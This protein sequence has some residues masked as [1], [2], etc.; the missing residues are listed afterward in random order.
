LNVDSNELGLSGVFQKP[1]NTN[2]LLRIL[3]TKLQ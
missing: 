1:L 3:K 2:S